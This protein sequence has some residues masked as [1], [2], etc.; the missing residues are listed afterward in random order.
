MRYIK[1]LPE[2]VQ[3]GDVY[4]FS[5]VDGGQPVYHTV[6]EICDRLV[7]IETTYKGIPATMYTNRYSEQVR[8]GRLIN[9]DNNS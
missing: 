1:I 8:F 7:G 3:P 2:Q 5:P 6:V 4:K 9:D